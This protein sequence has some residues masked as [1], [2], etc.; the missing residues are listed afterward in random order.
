MLNCSNII[1]SPPYET[2]HLFILYR[3]V[4]ARHTLVLSPDVIRNLLVFGLFKGG[5]VALLALTHEAFL[6]EVDTCE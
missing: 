4:R 5:L 6:N 1:Y 3:K 2:T